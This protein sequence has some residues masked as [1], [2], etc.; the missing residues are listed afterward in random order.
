MVN[1]WLRSER[2]WLEDLYGELIEGEVLLVQAPPRWGL[3]TACQEVAESLGESAILVDGRQVNEQNQRAFRE[4]LASRVH[5]VVDRTGWAQLI[6]DNYGRA[7]RRSQGG[8][9]HSVLYRM[10]ID[11]PQARDTG[12]LL[13][14]RMGDNLSLNFSGSPLISRAKTVVLPL[15]QGS[16]ADLRTRDIRDIRRLA[17]DSTWL[18]RRLLLD[19]DRQ[20]RVGV[21][22]HLSHHASRIVESLPAAAVGVLTGAI[23]ASEADSLSREALICLGTFE[24]GGNYLPATLVTESTLLA[25]VRRV[26]PTWPADLRRS[27]ER[28]AGLLAGAESAL[29]VDRYT[30][31]DPMQVRLFIELLRQQTSAHLRLLVSDDRERN[32]F[33]HTIADAL[34]G[35][36]GLEVRF[37]HRA[38]RKLLHD[39][40]LIIPHL[41]CGYVLPTSRVILALDHPGTAVAAR[42]AAVDYSTYWARASVVFPPN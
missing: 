3:T 41:R 33:A 18:A 22:E 7:I 40:H 5:D 19:G 42:I 37:M 10:L 8:I 35:L 13:T 38:D 23:D 20:G 28:F 1:N 2:R 15:L 30:L 39:R 27:V 29:W 34:Q 24:Q 9:L 25:E 17:G 12:A 4:D 6:F 36:D 31:H 14:A 26:N 21:V 11:S 16:D 32:N